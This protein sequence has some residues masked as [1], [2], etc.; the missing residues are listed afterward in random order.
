MFRQFGHGNVFPENLDLV[1]DGGIRVRDVDHAGIHAD[2]TYNRNPFPLDEYVADAV[3]QMT[4]EP[5]GIP[6]GD[7]GNP[8]GAGRVAFTSVADGL[9]FGNVADG[10]NVGFETAYGLE[11]GIRGTDA[12]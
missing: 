2:V 7:H 6:H 8:G 12:V 1:P 3:A 9:T 10:G 5:V 11:L 4:V